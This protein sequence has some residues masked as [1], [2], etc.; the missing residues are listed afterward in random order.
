MDQA[1]ARHHEHFLKYP[2][3]SGG[4]K[5]KKKS[6]LELFLVWVKPREA[7]FRAG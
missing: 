3:A 7:M 2:P 1:K 6:L 5:K 4:E